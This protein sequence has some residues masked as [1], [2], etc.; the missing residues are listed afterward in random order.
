MIAFIQHSK[1]GNPIG[2]LK[3]SIRT[4]SRPVITRAYGRQE[5][6]TEKEK[7]LH[8]GGILR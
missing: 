6:M 2:F 5:G 8:R 4:E 3:F 1:M 7:G